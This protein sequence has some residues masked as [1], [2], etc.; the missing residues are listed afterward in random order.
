M[1]EP[2][3]QGDDVHDDPPDDAALETALDLLD[4]TIC[5][6]G[7]V[8]AEHVP[9]EPYGETMGACATCDCEKFRPVAFTVTRA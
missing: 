4:G 5:E 2:D 7:C 6:C 8:D 1:I 9:L 3:D